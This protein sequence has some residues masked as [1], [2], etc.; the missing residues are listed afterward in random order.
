MQTWQFLVFGAQ[1]RLAK[2][3]RIHRVA[4]FSLD[5]E[6]GGRCSRK[7]LAQDGMRVLFYSFFNAWE[8][9]VAQCRSELTQC[10]DARAR[11]VLFIERR[12]EL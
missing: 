5:T 7:I 4:L 10:L 8:K 6:G 1:A 12:C 2:I 3:A 9:P 11:W